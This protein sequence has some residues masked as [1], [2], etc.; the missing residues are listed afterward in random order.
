MDP[1][2]TEDDAL[3]DDLWSDAPSGETFT[4]LVEAAQ[5]QCAGYAPKLKTDAAVP[6]RY[7]VA[8]VM[9]ARA[10]HRSF[11]AGGGDQIG[12]DGFTV[13]VWPMD[14]T[15]KALLRPPKLRAPR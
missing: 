11:L 5:D 9:Q 2:I 15:V 1:W 4:T 13:T 14:R 3:V 10:M 8:L 7:K 6:S 12:P